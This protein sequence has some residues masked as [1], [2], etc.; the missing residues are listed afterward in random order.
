MSKVI[1]GEDAIVQTYF[2]P[3]AAGYAGA[4]GLRD[5]CAVVTPGAGM[6]LVVKTD[7][8]RAGVHFFAN[9]PP[10]DI[11][12]KALAVNIS[13][14]AAKGAVPI[15]YVMSLSFPEVPTEDWLR[16]FTSGLAEAQAAFGCHLAGG[17]TDKAGGPISIAITAF[18]AVP[19]GRMVRRGG[20]GRAIASSCRGRSGIRGSDCICDNMISRG[21]SGRSIR[22]SGRI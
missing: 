9:D 3:L 2:A 5:D 10:A 13:D 8:V 6:D 19:A 7:P 17:D 16:S 20:R 15:A 4:F 18:G 22:R 21:G 11:A 14:L 1:G 12:W